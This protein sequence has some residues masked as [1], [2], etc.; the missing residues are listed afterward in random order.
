MGSIITLGIGKMEIDWGKN[1][2]YTDH[3]VLFQQA[4]VKDIPYYYV[5]L[6]TEE[7]IVEQKKGYSKKLI[8]VKQRLDMLGYSL[9]NLPKIYN[10][11]IEEYNE[12]YDSPQEV[13]EYSQFY[14]AVYNINLSKVNSLIDSDGYV[15]LVDNANG[16]DLGEYTRKCILNDPEILKGVSIQN[17]GD[18][19]YFLENIDPYITLRILAENP[20]NQHLELQWRYSDIVEGGWVK[21]EDIVCNLPDEYKVLIVTEGSSDSFIL[22]KSI[23]QLYPVIYDFFEFIDMEEGYPFTGVGSLF[24]FCKGLAKIHIR[25]NVIIIFDNDTAGNEKYEQAQK[26]ERPSTMMIWKLPEHSL[27]SNFDTKG[28]NGDSKSNING[29]AVSIECFLDFKEANPYIQWTS[30]NRTLHQYQGEI[31]PKDELVRIFKSVDLNNVEYDSNKLKFL[32]DNL[33]RDWIAF[34]Y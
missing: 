20:D 6:E 8:E 2:R 28:P 34:K 7:S 33:I 21:E 14:H 32:I 4:D 30:F 9:D 15:D 12:P 17:E 16:Y 18:I 13:I 31:Y 22:K 24:N 1:N 10:D 26:L 25:N 29:K 5:D 23:K 27:F 3:S 19:S 11:F